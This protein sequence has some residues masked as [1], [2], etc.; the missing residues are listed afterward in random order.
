MNGFS[1]LVVES[2]E[3]DSIKSFVSDASSDVVEAVNNMQKG[4]P[5]E[6]IK[7]DYSGDS[8]EVVILGWEGSVK[9]QRAWPQER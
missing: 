9:A 4:N 1:N 2:D 8:N 5:E 7:Q 3:Y 6:K